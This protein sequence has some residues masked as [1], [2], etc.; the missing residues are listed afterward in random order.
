MNGKKLGLDWSLTDLQEP[1]LPTVIVVVV[2]DIYTEK[3]QH[4]QLQ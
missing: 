2:A 1:N 3:Q 4:V